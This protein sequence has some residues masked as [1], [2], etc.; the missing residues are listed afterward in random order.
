MERTAVHLPCLLLLHLELLAHALQPTPR[1]R[2]AGLRLQHL[3]KVSPRLVPLGELHASRAVTV[4]C[5]AAPRIELERHLG[6]LACL[7]PV[8][9]FEGALRAVEEAEQPQLL[10]GHLLLGSVVA[11]ERHSVDRS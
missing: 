1:I 10:D 2:I 3:L 11:V 8:G 6:V 4:A 7:H 9:E 5:L